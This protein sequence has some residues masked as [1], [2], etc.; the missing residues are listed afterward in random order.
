[1]S[2]F[3]IYY[4]FAILKIRK[5]ILIFILI[6]ASSTIYWKTQTFFNLF[7]SLKLGLTIFKISKIDNLFF[8]P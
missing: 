5:N 7:Y 8:R 2:F 1:M 4:I 3:L 6:S